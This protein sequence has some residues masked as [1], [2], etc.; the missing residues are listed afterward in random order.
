MVQELQ[1]DPELRTQAEY[2]QIK[3]AVIE[4][5]MQD[6]ARPNES[7]ELDRIKMLAGV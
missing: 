2:Y 6:M 3:L 5:L 7:V 1:G 4:K